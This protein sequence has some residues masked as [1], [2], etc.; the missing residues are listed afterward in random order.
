MAPEL[1]NA[2][3]AFIIASAIFA[4]GFWVASAINDVR[5][6]E[7]RTIQEQISTD[8]LSLETQFDLLTRLSCE[9]IAENSVLSDE[10]NDL[11][12]RLDY[13]EAQLGSKNSTVLLLKRQYSLLEIKDYLL[14]QQVATKCKLK[15]VFVLYFYS[16]QG[17][18][19]KCDSAG[20][21]L[22]YLRETY[23]QLRVYSFDYNLDLGALD[24]LIAINKI[25]NNLPAFSVNG[26]IHYGLSDLESIE[27]ILPL[28]KLATST[29]TT[30][31]KAR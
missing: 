24:T 22:T 30:T 11:S 8:T 6:S 10:L 5:L 12:E 25:E 26:K 15:P 16:N 2:I 27:K 7:I 28:D 23:P 19:E 17:D 14:M 21:V 9:E 29:A 20:H 1:R 4:T 31:Q 13:T 18:C 3:L